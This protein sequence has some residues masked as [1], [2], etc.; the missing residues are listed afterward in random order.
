MVLQ[1]CKTNNKKIRDQK[2]YSKLKHKKEEMTIEEFINRFKNS[3]LSV[4]GGAFSIWGCPFGKIGD[5]Y[6]KITKVDFNSNLQILQFDTSYVKV[7]ICSPKGIEEKVSKDGLYPPSIEIEKAD[8]IRLEY[9]FK[10]N[11]E[12]FIDFEFNTKKTESNSDW[13]N[14]RNIESSSRKAMIFA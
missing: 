9:I 6:Y 2:T 5:N 3:E 13:Y 4:K 7:R 8:R 12:Y 1:A 11:T 10:K 14:N